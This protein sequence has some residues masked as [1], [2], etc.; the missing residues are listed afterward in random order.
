MDVKH[1][2]AEQQRQVSHIKT[3]TAHKI[4]SQTQMMEQLQLQLAS[5]EDK[6]TQQQAVRKSYEEKSILLTRLKEDLTAQKE[7]L[8]LYTHLSTVIQQLEEEQHNYANEIARLS[9]EKNT[10]QRDIDYYT[11][12][13]IKSPQEYIQELG[14][15]KEQL[16]TV[17]HAINNM[18][19]AQKALPLRK[20]SLTKFSSH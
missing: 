11:Q 1:E 10:L 14:A 13:Q 12:E 19:L 7:K 2:L 16:K 15:L 18:I 4:T 6:M 20:N 5:I 17:N 8:T 3:T 9:G